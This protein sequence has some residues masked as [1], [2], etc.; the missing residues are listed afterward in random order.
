[1]RSIQ[2]IGRIGIGALGLVSLAC[3][4]ATLGPTGDGGTGGGRG[5]AGGDGAG[6]D[7]GAGRGCGGDTGGS[8]GTGGTGGAAKF[9]LPDC[10]QALVASCPTSGTCVSEETDAET[11]S[12]RC[13]SCGVRVTFEGH[14]FGTGGTEVA[15]ISNADGTPCYSFQTSVL[16]G[17][18]FLYVWKD[19]AGQVVAT[20]RMGADPTAT[21]SPGTPGPYGQIQCEG[22]GQMS[23]CFGGDSCCDIAALGNATCAGQ[24]ISCAT[25]ACP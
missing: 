22:G 10:V 2:S 5:G 12:P 19:P 9:G 13:F 1:M 11:P 25:G 21:P 4:Q 23:A 8:V 17:E 24:R 15:Y 18:V 14:I 7:G 6:T 3:G 20:G 16:G